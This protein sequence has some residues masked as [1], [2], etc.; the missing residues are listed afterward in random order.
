MAVVAAAAVV[1][2]AADFDVQTLVVADSCRVRTW[3]FEGP[4]LG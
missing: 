4:K 1:V 3:K 2:A